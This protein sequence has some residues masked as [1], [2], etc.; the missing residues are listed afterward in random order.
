MVLEIGSKWEES[1]LLVWSSKGLFPDP[2]FENT[3]LACFLSYYIR[4]VGNYSDGK[5]WEK[6][7]LGLSCTKLASLGISKWEN[8]TCCVIY[9]AAVHEK[10][11][12]RSLLGGIE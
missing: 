5:H 4:Q 6:K 2:K 3:T 7:G 10:R 11:L 9:S 12:L 8:G 1:G